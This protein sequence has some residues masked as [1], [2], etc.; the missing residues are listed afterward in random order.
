MMLRFNLT[1][2]VE[3]PPARLAVGT[4]RQH[5]GLYEQRRRHSARARRKPEATGRPPE[6]LYHGPLVRGV[7]MA[8]QEGT[9][10][11]RTRA[12]NEVV[13]TFTSARARFFLSAGR[14]LEIRSPVEYGHFESSPEELGGNMSANEPKTGEEDLARH[15]VHRLHEFFYACILQMIVC[16]NSV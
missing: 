4:A 3:L 8:T 1:G 6:P 12:M 5:L 14:C 9:V 2:P 7:Q 11:A 13:A 10:V 16:P 15:S